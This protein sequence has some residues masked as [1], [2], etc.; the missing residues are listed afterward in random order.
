[1]REICLCSFEL[2][3]LDCF[4]PSWFFIAIKLTCN[5]GKRH[6]SCGGPCRNFVFQV[7]EKRKLTRSEGPFERGKGLKETRSLWPPQRGVGLQEPNLGKTN[8]RVSLLIRLRFVLCPLAD[9][10]LF[11]T[12]TRLVVVIICKNFS[13]ALFTPPLGDYQPP[14]SI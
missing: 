3:R 1:V 10:F 5:W 2:L 14:K 12:L 7:I 8:P 11:L 6:Q 9:S 4:L 13:F